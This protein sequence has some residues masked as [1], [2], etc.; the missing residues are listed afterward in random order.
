MND[1]L[2][3]LHFKEAAR[4]AAGHYFIEAKIQA[5]EALRLIN[6]ADMDAR[7]FVEPVETAL[8]V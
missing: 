1:A 8:A 2:I 6:Q 5:L 7:E 4:C 3:Q